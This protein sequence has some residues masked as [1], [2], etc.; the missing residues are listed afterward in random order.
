MVEYLRFNVT[1]G[2]RADLNFT[3]ND[4]GALATF[5]SILSG[6]S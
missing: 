3:I 1:S 4:I 5:Q 2:D 6:M